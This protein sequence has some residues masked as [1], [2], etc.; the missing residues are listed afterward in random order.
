MASEGYLNKAVI[1][2]FSSPLARAWPQSRRP[3]RSAQSR[4]TGSAWTA[5]LPRVQSTAILRFCLNTCTRCP[6]RKSSA[7]DPESVAGET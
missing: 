3:E 6:V 1:L 4:L 7:S 5:L 2:K